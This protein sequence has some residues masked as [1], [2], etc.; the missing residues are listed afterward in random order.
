MTA[1]VATR[2]F[3]ALNHERD[4]GNLRRVF[5]N[6][7]RILRSGGLLLF[8]PN[9]RYFLE[10]LAGSENLGAPGAVS[11][12]MIR[13]VP[14]SSTPDALHLAVTGDS[15]AVSAATPLG[16]IPLATC[17]ATGG[18]WLIRLRFHG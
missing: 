14:G 2:H 10:W 7:A 11:V 17:L 13:P 16:L 5:E 12:S 9:T 6:T 18:R 3:D 4:A 8:D 1:D 15:T